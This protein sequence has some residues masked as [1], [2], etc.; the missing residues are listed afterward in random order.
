MHLDGAIATSV[1]YRAYSRGA[2]LIGP[3]AGTGYFAI[4]PDLQNQD[5]AILTIDTV[6]CDLPDLQSKGFAF[7][8]VAKLYCARLKS[9][10]EIRSWC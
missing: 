1:T 2:V 7:N 6:Y 10:L 3:H 4:R 8:L 9:D 5:A